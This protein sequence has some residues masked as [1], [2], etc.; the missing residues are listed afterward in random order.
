MKKAYVYAGIGAWMAAIGL[1]AAAVL[2]PDGAEDGGGG[3]AAPAGHG[4][5]DV[6]THRT[7]ADTAIAVKVTGA[8]VQ[9]DSRAP[10]T[11]FLGTCTAS[12]EAGK[13]VVTVDAA[14]TNLSSEEYYDLKGRF[15]L[16]DAGGDRRPASSSFDPSSSF[17]L[18]VGF[19]GLPKGQT[20]PVQLQYL[21]DP[22]ASE[23][24]LVIKTDWSEDETRIALDGAVR[25]RPELCSGG[26]RC[27]AG[28][29][30]G[31]AG[32]N[33][34]IL[35]VEDNVRKEIRLS[36][37]DPP[38]AGERL[39]RDYLGV[40]EAFCPAG[41]YAVFDEDG[42]LGG[43][44]EDMQVGKLY[45]E[46]EPVNEQVLDMG[47]ATLDLDDCAGSEYAAEPWARGRGC[48]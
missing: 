25:H 38:G 13:Y 16:E 20:M 23:Y 33:I 22:P 47:L 12:R 48:G 46:G 14:V 40:L 28:F 41:A 10:Q 27:F 31:N 42:G 15:E 35:D 39:H 21:V 1:I 11:C 5:G 7:T 30:A 44:R 43:G 3:A 8:S 45:C 2:L 29:V 24:T 19:G 32:G 6:V 36:L 18:S 26:G 9:L 4:M 34:T 17:D 37:V